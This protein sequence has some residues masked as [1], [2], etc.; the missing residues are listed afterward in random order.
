MWTSRVFLLLVANVCNSIHVAKCI[1]KMML[2]SS[3]EIVTPA[4]LSMETAKTVYPR[5]C[6]LNLNGY[7]SQKV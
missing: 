5:K 2:H 1:S 7:Q 6:T 3:L 4:W